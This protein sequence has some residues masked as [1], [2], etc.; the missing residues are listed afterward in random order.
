MYKAEQRQ[1]QMESRLQALEASGALKQDVW[2]NPQ[3]Q[4]AQAE[5]QSLRREVQQLQVGVDRVL[6]R[7][8]GAS[9]QSHFVVQPAGSSSLT[10]LLLPF[11]F[12]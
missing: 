7:L 3:G 9:V 5:L 2:A 4:A 6:P 11:N 12:F 1:Q 8:V 10:L